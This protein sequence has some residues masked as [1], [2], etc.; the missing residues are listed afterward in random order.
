M[1]NDIGWHD[2]QMAMPLGMVARW[3]DVQVDTC[4]TIYHIL[5]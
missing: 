3:P 4:A 1:H 5:L 2:C